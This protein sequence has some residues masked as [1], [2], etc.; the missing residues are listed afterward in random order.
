MYFLGAE[1]QLVTESKINEWTGTAGIGEM[2]GKKF[3]LVLAPNFKKAKELA[4]L[5]FDGLLQPIEQLVNGVPIYCLSKRSKEGDQNLLTES[6][7]T[8]SPNPKSES[9]LIEIFGK[10]R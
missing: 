4:D 1:P 7:T 2:N 9:D 3:V 5:Y 8:I 6:S 10:E